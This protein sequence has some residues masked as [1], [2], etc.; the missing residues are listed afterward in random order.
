[1]TNDTRQRT[2]DP[3]AQQPPLGPPGASVPA[4]RPVA[5]KRPWGWLALALVAVVAGG[6]AY[7][8]PWIA[9]PP[10]VPFETASLAPTTQVLAVNGRI[11]AVHSVVVRPLVSGALQ[12]LLVNE[13]DRVE[14]GQVLA[15]ID[16]DA[17]NAVVRQAIAGHDAALVAQTQAQETYDR[18]LALGANVSRTTLDRDARAVETAGQEVARMAALLDQA[19][20]ALNRYTIRAPIGGTVLALSADEGQNVDP[21]TALMTLADLSNL[22]VETDVD[23]IYATQITP[24]QPVILQLAGETAT[25]AGHVSFVSDRIEVTTGGLA[26]RLVFEDPVAAPVGLTVTANIIISQTDAALTVPRAALAT[27]DARRGVFV[28]EDGVATF[29]PLALI[30]WPAARLIVTSGL[31]EGERVILDAAG[32]TD[33]QAVRLEPSE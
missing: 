16:A 1:M 8:Q 21:S 13:G 28:I 15:R 19:Q 30:D 26:V 27:E 23:E 18:S 7:F 32:I 10:L 3:A 33:G 14:T 22:M 17:Q 25:R 29:R 5:R 4:L 31:A 24:G 6:L 11:A 9:R 12:A 20:I 2:R